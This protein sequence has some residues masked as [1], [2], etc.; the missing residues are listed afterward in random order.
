MPVSKVYRGSSLIGK[1]GFPN[2]NSIRVDSAS[3]VLIFGTGASGTTEKTAVDT[4]STQTLTNKTLTSPAIAGTPVLN[5]VKGNFSAAS[6]AA[7]YAADTYLAGSSIAIPTGGWIAGGRYVCVFDMVKTAAG[8]A[9]FTITLRLGNAGTTADASIISFAFAAGTAAVDTG[10]FE[11][12]CH[13]RTVGATTTAVMVGTAYCSHALAATGLIS[14]GASGVGQ[15]TTV[16]SGF[17]STTA[18]GVLG[19][20]VNGGASFSGTNTI[21]EAEYHSF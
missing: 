6:V 12:F 21:V 20:S 19:L 8:T 2:A 13:F 9:Q 3:D 4:S 15:I 5:T 14:T 17:D 10:L 11:I 7:G 18:N 16:S 1:A